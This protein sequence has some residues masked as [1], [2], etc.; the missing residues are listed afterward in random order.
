MPAGYPYVLCLCAWPCTQDGIDFEV[1]SRNPSYTRPYYRWQ[2]YIDTA[3]QR[4][5][6]QYENAAREWDDYMDSL[7]VEERVEV[8]VQ[9]TVPP[10]VQ[11]IVQLSVQESPVQPVQP[12]AEPP[13]LPVQPVQADSLVVQPSVQPD[14]PPVLPVVQ[15]AVQPLEPA[16]QPP[17]QPLEASS[18]ASVQVY[19]Q[20]PAHEQPAPM[21]P[22]QRAE[23]PADQRTLAALEQSGMQPA[24]QSPQQAGQPPAEPVSPPVQA[25]QLTEPPAHA[26]KETVQ[27]P[28]QT[29]AL[30]QE[31]P[32]QPAVQPVKS[33]VQVSVL[34]VQS[35]TDAAASSS[36]G[37]CHSCPLPCL[38]GAHVVN[39]HACMLLCAGSGTQAICRRVQAAERSMVQARARWWAGG[40]GARVWPLR[41]S[42]RGQRQAICI[43]E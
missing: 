32:L 33:H 36:A 18:L 24:L 29:H 6:A 17:A 37:S 40:Q 22:Q 13:V 10:E 43:I 31:V 12:A 39:W 9:L 19:E 34:H 5:W 26:A 30:P 11:Q 4:L 2:K 27:P 16:V 8:T 28:A 20:P 21:Q 38:H 14:V 25:E 23:S 42:G 3:E 41:H 7:S 35:A 1:G 15:S